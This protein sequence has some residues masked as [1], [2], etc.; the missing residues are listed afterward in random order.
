MFVV[1]TTRDHVSPWHSVYRIHLLVD[2]EISFLLT[3]GGH[4]AGIVSEPGHKNRSYQV[5][6]KSPTDQYVDPDTW[7]AAAPRQEGSWWPEWVSW[8]E[9]RSGEPVPPP[10]MA[11]PEA[12]YKMLADAP[13][14]YVLQG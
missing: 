3:S 5:M 14:I 9:M 10:R 11:A 8:L 12:G 2:N 7:A 1:G 13:G 6:T 4:N